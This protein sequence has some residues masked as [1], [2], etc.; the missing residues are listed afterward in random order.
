MNKRLATTVIAVVVIAGAFW[1]WQSHTA[2]CRNRSER[3]NSHIEELRKSAVREIPRGSSKEDVVRF[4]NSVG[5]KP[6][7]DKE[8]RFGGA[9]FYEEGCSPF[10]C[11]R[12]TAIVGVHVKFDSSGRVEST[13]VA[14]MYIDCL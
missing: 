7:F 10:G 3:L 6:A 12:D 11:G 1:V 13:D 14:S 9:D 5:L 2:K 8:A 4:F